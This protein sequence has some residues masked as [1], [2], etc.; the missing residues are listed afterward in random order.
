[1][2]DDLR[3]NCG[4]AMRQLQKHGVTGFRIAPRRGISDWLQTEGMKQMWRTAAETRQPMCCLINP[5]D[6]PAVNAACRRHPDTPVVI[7]HFA[8]IGI[9][10]TIRESD[11]AQLCDL[12]RHP[13]V[14]VKI[15]A[16]YALGNKRA[17]HTELIPMIRRLLDAYGP[18]RLMWASDSPYQINEHNTYESS[19]ALVS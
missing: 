5:S 16:Y 11:V 14:K 7:D 2:V 12:A 13:H 3:P 9:D 8:R 18:Q 1:M 19:L 15:S 6:L 17:P 4:Q 10:S